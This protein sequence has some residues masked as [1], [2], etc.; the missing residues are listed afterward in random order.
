MASTN[1]ELLV[2][3]SF[4]EMKISVSDITP[5]K[6]KD[7]LANNDNNRRLRQD[8]INLYAS[9]MTAGNWKLN[10]VPIVLDDTGELRD[11]QH[12]LKAIIKS[13]KTMKNTV[14]IK[15][16]KEQANCYDI[17]AQRSVMDIAK[18]AGYQDEPFFRCSA[19]CSAV[20]IAIEGR[21]VSSNYSKMKIINQML[22]YSDAC[23]FVYNNLYTKAG[24]KERYRLR[25]S[26]LYGAV[27]N[28]YLNG[29]DQTLLER[30]CNILSYGFAKEE[31]E[32]PTIRL[33]DSLLIAKE[34]TRQERTKIYYQ[35]QYAL[36]A[37]ENK[38][39]KIDIH[40]ANKEYYP[41]PD[42]SMKEYLNNES[43]N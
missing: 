36:Y 27:I 16:P 7:L 19:V 4:G 14:I 18:L 31:Y 9:E 3:T 23:K 25:N 21:A 39:A 40:K 13:N 33:R 12:R 34:R 32:I 38:L 29:F 1:K 26:C 17:G 42:S 30:F 2:N 10:G 15:L 22:K 28:A 11:G 5:K 8:R 37:L 20:K 43:I 41:Y 35:S 24:S 6:A